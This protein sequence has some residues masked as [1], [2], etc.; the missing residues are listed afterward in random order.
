MRGTCLLSLVDK[1]L[2]AM[3]S[4]RKSAALRIRVPVQAI[5]SPPNSKDDAVIHNP[6]FSRPNDMPS[7]LV[8]GHNSPDEALDQLII[9]AH[10]LAL[11]LRVAALEANL[12]DSVVTLLAA[13]FLR[14]WAVETGKRQ[15]E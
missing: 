12:V 2:M 9:R 13:D 6:E 14:Y 8:K 5:P 1:A 7:L 10:Y 3:R 4:M 15:V 11:D